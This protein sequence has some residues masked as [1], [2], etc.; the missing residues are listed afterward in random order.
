MHANQALL[1]I[2]TFA[3]FRFFLLFSPPAIADQ[4]KRA[5]VPIAGFQ[6]SRW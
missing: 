4:S 2:A 6:S 1:R 5:Y 3:I